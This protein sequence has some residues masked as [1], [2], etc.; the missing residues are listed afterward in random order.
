MLYST[1][2][3][4]CNLELH[5][6]RGNEFPFFRH[7]KLCLLQESLYEYCSLWY[8]HF[9]LASIAQFL[10]ILIFGSLM[11]LTV[12][13]TLLALIA[14]GYGFYFSFCSILHLLP[15]EITQ[16]FQSLSFFKCKGRQCYL[17]LRFAMSMIWNGKY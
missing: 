14:E 2:I 8:N 15:L 4:S 6:H 1:V 9:P 10:W 3:K 7:L 12:T 13:E 16:I 5:H 17:T 11:Q